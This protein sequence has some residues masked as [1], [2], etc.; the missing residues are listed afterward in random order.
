MIVLLSEPATP[1]QA[2]RMLEDWKVLVKVVVDVRRDVLAGGGEVHVDGLALLLVEGSRRED[3]WGATW[4]S[5]SREAMLEALV[6]VKPRHGNAWLRIENREERQR[7][8]VTV[9][10]LLEGREGGGVLAEGPPGPLPRDRRAARER[11]LREAPP[12]RLASIATVLG[13]AASVAPHA[14]HAASTA[15]LV[16][17]ARHV[18]EWTAA[19]LDPSG[20]AELVDLQVALT[21]WLRLWA[22]GRA[23]PVQRALLAHEAGR[24]SQRAG[25]LSAVAEGDSTPPASRPG[26]A[27]AAHPDAVRRHTGPRRTDPVGERG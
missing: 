19:E 17:E 20:A 12:G 23:D 22:T 1:E 18:I 10:R 9:R 7:V 2:A 27:R 15:E 3:L 5:E 21:L 8:E 13:R 6:N 4:Y 25:E 26:V 16:D 11:F 24:W 14:G